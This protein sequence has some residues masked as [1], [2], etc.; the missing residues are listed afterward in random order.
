MPR[1]YIPDMHSLEKARVSG[2]ERLQLGV[3]VTTALS[4]DVLFDCNFL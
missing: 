2:V 4:V 3:V 1:S